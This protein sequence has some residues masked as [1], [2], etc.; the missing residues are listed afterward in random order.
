MSDKKNTL[1]A[2]KLQYGVNSIVL[3]LTV[4][5]VVILI[6][7]IA[8]IKPVRLDLTSNKLY[9]IS[10]ATK[11]VLSKLNK[12]V[13]IVGL[14]DDGKI[15]S[16]YR[17]IRDL[18]EQ[19]ALNSGSH[20]SVKYI[21]PDKSTGIIKQLDPNGSKNLKKN[22]FVILSGEKARKLSYEDL[23]QVELN[24]QTLSEYVSGS[25]AEQ[26]FTNA[27][28]DVS[29]GE[30]PVVYFIAENNEE[31]FENQYK[32]LNEALTKK[33]LTVKTLKFPLKDGVP[34]DAEVLIF[35][36]PKKDLS[37][38]ESD[39]IKKYL[40]SGGRAVFLFDPASS[41]GFKRFE[42]IINDY[43]LSLKN[44]KIMEKGENGHIPDN[45]YGLI[46]DVKQSPAISE[47]FSIVLSDSAS[48]R[49]LKNENDSVTVI[50]LV[51]SSNSSLSM[52]QH[53]TGGSG[54]PAP[55]DLAVAV[56]KQDLSSN[57]RIAVIGSGSFLRET[58]KNQYPSYF[59]NGLYFF[60]NVLQWVKDSREE[61]AIKPRSYNEQVVFID[62]F[63]A[64]SIGLFV[65]FF[66]PLIIFG[67]GLFVWLRRRHL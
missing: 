49:T 30:T 67:S 7:L 41:G 53:E 17:D 47:E 31:P 28:R 44:D 42:A 29:N 11:S 32:S 38:T 22:D 14:F 61:I 36:S 8:D 63:T 20:I 26:K 33:E 15:D 27:V 66:I 43:H 54:S 50:P 65:I 16:D 52:E 9:S 12:D 51:K 5:A 21:D 3:T 10:D 24:R 59:S 39:K 19:Y 55:F 25:L 40:D 34:H 2:R 37:E 60:T 58:A 13:E 56:Q 1:N 57:S 23:F 62:R 48:I 46:V 4:I 64:N 45:P 18:L 35:A 6:N